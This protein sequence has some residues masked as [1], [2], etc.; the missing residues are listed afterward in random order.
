MH[1]DDVKLAL[2][3]ALGDARVFI[4]RKYRK[5]ALREMNEVLPQIEADYYKAV[6]SGKAFRLD[7]SK[8]L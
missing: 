8:Y 3:D 5:A 2:D 1:K 7:T 4:N 6:N